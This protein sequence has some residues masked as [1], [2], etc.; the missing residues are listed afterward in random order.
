MSAIT[1]S[2]PKVCELR[3]VVVVGIPVISFGW[4]QQLRDLHF[5]FLHM[6]VFTRGGLWW[7]FR[8]EDNDG[9]WHVVL[10]W[11][12]LMPAAG[13][14]VVGRGAVDAC[15]RIGLEPIFSCGYESS[16]YPRAKIPD[17]G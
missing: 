8:P 14:I 1:L 4:L 3:V 15:V 17:V 13:D 7:W 10:V 6:P 11:W 5:F 12:R 16:R 9:H 2:L